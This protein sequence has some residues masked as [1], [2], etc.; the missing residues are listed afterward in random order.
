MSFN[1]CTSE[2]II[3]KSGLNANSTAIASTALMAD[4]CDKA[5]G[6]FCMKT[7]KDWVA[8][9]GS[10][11]IMQ[12]VADAVSDLA[13]IKVINYDPDAIGRS[14][15]T[16][17]LDVLTDNSDTIIKDLRNKEFHKFS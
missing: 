7:R 6:H 10:T 9:A 4:Y 17:R 14:L 13:G 11:V 12:A 2:A 15:A 1:L 5:E 8:N 16:L 3:R